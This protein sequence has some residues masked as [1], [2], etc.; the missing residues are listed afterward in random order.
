MLTAFLS[1]T[2]TTAIAEADRLDE[3]SG[4]VFWRFELRLDLG[5]EERLVQYAFH[6][7][8]V[9]SER[10]WTAFLC[11]CHHCGHQLKYLTIP[12][13]CDGPC[14]GIYC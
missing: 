3:Y 13:A 10:R 6:A 7:D 12:S 4:W 2:G 5:E 1:Y 14:C 9:D 11:H 8:G